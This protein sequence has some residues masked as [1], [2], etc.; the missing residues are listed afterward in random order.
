MTYE[1]RQELDEKA[2][3]TIQLCLTKEVLCEFIHEQITIGLWLKLELL[4]MTES[5]DNKLRLKEM[6]YTI[7]MAEGTFVQ[8]HLSE[9]NLLL[10]ILRI[11]MSRL[12]MGIKTCY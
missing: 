12:K 4:Y 11:W 1:H 3:S 9:F 8:S 6:L 2:L 5:L 10:L 7:R